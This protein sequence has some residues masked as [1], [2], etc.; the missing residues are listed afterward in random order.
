MKLVKDTIIMIFGS[1]SK[2]AI[3]L[4]Y[5][6]ILSRTISKIE[7]GTYNQVNLV[8]STILPFLIIGLPISLSYF[9][10]RLTDSSIKKG[11]LI[12][13][14][15]IMN[16]LGLI[17]F[18]LICFTADYIS[19]IYNNYE[20]QKYFK[21]Y[22]IFIFFDVGASFYPNFY[23]ATER[24]KKLAKL[25]I[26]FSLFRLIALVIAVLVFK[27]SLTSIFVCLLLYAFLKYIFILV[28]VFVFYKKVK[29]KLSK[30][31]LREQL[32]YSVPLGLSTIIGIVIKLVDKNVVSASFTTEQYAIYSN[33]AFEIPFID[34]IT[35]SIT[36]VLL[37]DFCKK[38][39]SD[40]TN[41]H[42]IINTWKKAMVMSSIVLIPIMLALLVFSK[43]LILLLFSEKYFN[44]VPI[45]NIYL[46]LLPIRTVN[47]SS[48]LMA[49]K[50]QK[51]IMYNSIITLIVGF[52]LNIVFI[53]FW[54]YYGAAIASVVA[55]Y[56]LAFLQTI[57]ICKVYSV[58]FK[59]VYPWKELFKIFITA[60]TLLI[61]F[62]IINTY[63]N[64]SSII[65]FLLFGGAYLILCLIVFLRTNILS[66]EEILHLV[67]I[68]RGQVV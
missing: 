1:G 5:I 66:K 23:L 64:I 41:N 10:P 65:K 40:G 15:I 56:F 60:L 31:L 13:T 21:F 7:Y 25:T 6:I 51:L 27:G 36:S 49:S 8:F 20:L 17:G 62:I 19:F 30:N 57:Q 59:N 16:F 50:N 44:S 68:K 29:L 24:A 43:G 3:D 9:L 26:Q 61:P 67:N 22:S 28:D 38:Y 11:L 47:Y 46:I 34:V 18:L 53:Q 4:I 63:L 39:K 32:L 35:G 2:Q 14:I 33:G 42:L 48:L 58:N 12:Q 45:F 37:P 52:V 54:G 55:I